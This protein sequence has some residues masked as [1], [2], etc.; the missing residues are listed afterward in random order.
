VGY[1]RSCKPLQS[2]LPANSSSRQDVDNKRSLGE[3]DRNSTLSGPIRYWC[4]VH[5][6]QYPAKVL[7]HVF[8]PIFYLYLLCSSRSSLLR[9]LN[10]QFSNGTPRRNINLRLRDPL[11][12]EWVF[13]VNRELRIR[14]HSSEIRKTDLEMTI[15]DPVQNFFGIRSEIFGGTAPRVGL[16]IL[17]LL[18]ESLNTE[19]SAGAPYSSAREQIQG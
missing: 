15:L 11:R 1:R 7:E 6:C 5:Q 10:Q 3:H 14:T 12:S 2:S 9:N 18:G 8:I 13:L 16:V 4:K 19:N 17:R